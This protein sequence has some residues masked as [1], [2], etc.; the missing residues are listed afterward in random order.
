MIE[1]INVM[2]KILFI[3]AG[4]LQSYIIQ[5]AKAL[6]Y[7]TCAVDANANAIGFYYLTSVQ[8]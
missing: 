7:I 5:K 1:K 2:K 6:G 8:S 3:G 4:F